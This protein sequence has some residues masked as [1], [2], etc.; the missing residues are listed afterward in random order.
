MANYNRIVLVGNATRD[1]E[2]KHLP[3]GKA[4]GSTGLAC[5]DRY[6]NK[7]GEWVED[8]L[9]V[10]VK[11]WGRTAEVANEYI[12]KGDQFLVEGRLKLERW[13]KDGTKHSKHTVTCDKLQLLG[14]KRDGGGSGA[15]TDAD[16][17]SG[18]EGSSSSSGIPE[19]E[20]PF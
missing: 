6:K 17:G 14:G 8:P 3:D 18:S 7:A 5:N 10:D 15:P 2:L 11:F 19:E 9:F 4:V 20:I 12:H 16:S 13:E 1:I